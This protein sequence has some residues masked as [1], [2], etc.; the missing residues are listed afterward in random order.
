[1]TK[2][3]IDLLLEYHCRIVTDLVNEMKADSKRV[4]EFDSPE[5]YQAI[6][7]ARIETLTHVFNNLV[8]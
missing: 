2:S 7:T 8:I 3:K 1:M 5:V 4:S 6:Q